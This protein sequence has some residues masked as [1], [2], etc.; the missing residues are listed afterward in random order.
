MRPERGLRAWVEIRVQS[1][2]VTALEWDPRKAEANVRKHQVRFADAVS[3]LD[4]DQA[5]TVGEAVGTEE[6]WVTIG[7]DALGRILRGKR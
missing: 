4:D 6:R 5:I 2:T 1:Y 7:L 3:V